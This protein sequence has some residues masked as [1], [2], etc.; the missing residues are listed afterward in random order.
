MEKYKVTGTITAYLV[1]SDS[2]HKVRYYYGYFLRKEDAELMLD[3]L[4]GMTASGPEKGTD[5]IVLV[6]SLEAVGG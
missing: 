3:S 1:W 4:P 2:N 6:K 5:E